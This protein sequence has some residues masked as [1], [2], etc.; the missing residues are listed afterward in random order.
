MEAQVV[1]LDGVIRDYAWGSSTAI[2]KL[3]GIAPDGRPAAEL[4][5]GD[6]AGDPSL[7]P[8][9]GTTLDTLIA[10]DPEAALGVDSVERFGPHLPFLLKVLAAERA[11]SLQVHPTRD[12]ARSGFAA[13]EAAGVPRDA[14]ERNYS[15]TNHKPEL[16]CALTRFDALCGFRPIRQSIALL[17]DL[18]S[19]QLGF[20][21]ELLR[22]PDGLRAAFSAVLAHDEPAALA[23]AVMARLGC[24]DARLDGVRL[25]AEHF[26]DDIGV[27][28]A[29]L[30]NHVRLEPG[31]AIFNGSGTVHAYLR[32]TGVEI[33][34]SS[35]NVLRCGLTPKHIDIAELLKTTDFAELSDPR[36]RTT[37]LGAVRTFQAPAADFG[38]EVLD[39]DADAPR[40][41]VDGACIV[42]CVDEPLR[43]GVGA[44]SVA[45]APGHAAFVAAGAGTM[46]IR[47]EGHAF[48]A[49][50]G[51][52][53]AG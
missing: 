12:Q 53:A 37:A 42:L 46:T 10:A 15:D 40:L 2:P 22:G 26:P 31:E 7:V 24:D 35:D 28:V 14:P 11:L 49:S 9:L 47:G 21:A 25:A 51:S 1:A 41:N 43:V 44:T 4:W 45:V 38:L 29:L 8:A 32:G 39:L 27:V 18:A 50:P 33:M 23:A 48:L 16:L 36:C 3:L 17:D 52:A 19:T 34:A 20:L 30:L 5:F 13:E 6:H